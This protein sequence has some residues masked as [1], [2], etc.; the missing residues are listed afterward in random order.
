[1]IKEINVIGNGYMGSQLSSLFCLMNYK[2]NIFYNKNKNEKNFLNNFK[3]LKKKYSKINLQINYEYFNSLNDLKNYPT[4]ECVS[5]NFEIKKEVFDKIFNK[6]QNNVFSN[7]SSI[8]V[9]EINKKLSIMHFMNPIFLGVVEIYRS[10]NLNNHG[11]ELIDSLKNEN[12]TIINNKS[13]NEIVLNKI[14]FSEISHFFDLIEKQK[15]DKLELLNSVSKIK[16]YNFLNILDLIG[17]DTC[18]QIL[19][20][21]NK[22][23]TNF[24]IPN[25]FKIALEQEVLGKKNK[26]TI[27]TIFLSKN[28][29]D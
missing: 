1:M 27:N 20:N 9:S 26:K 18:Y 6:L 22:V 28:Y 3:I 17:I 23:N 13:S 5:E 2:V 29:P 15:T 25:I 11:E 7:T 4:I 14:I 12:F 10:R 21:L 16:G 24:Y 8:D 19:K